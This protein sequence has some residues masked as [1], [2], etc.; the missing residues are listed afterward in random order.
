MGKRLHGP[1]RAKEWRPSSD[2]CGACF[3]SSR[4]KVTARD[5]ML[6]GQTES[7]SACC[8]DQYHIAASI[9]NPVGPCVTKF[10]FLN[11]RAKS[12]DPRSRR[13]AGA[14]ACGDVF[15]DNALRGWE[16]QFGGGL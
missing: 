6:T 16:A 7:Q 3:G 5:S 1:V 12:D 9:Q 14:N 11:S 10:S 2:L 8:A 13:L 15:E 4:W